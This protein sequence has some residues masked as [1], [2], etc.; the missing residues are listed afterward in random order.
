LKVTFANAPSENPLGAEEWFERLLPVPIVVVSRALAVIDLPHPEVVPAAESFAV[1]MPCPA[2]NGV[3]IAILL[4]VVY[5]GPTMVP[6]VAFRTF[7]TVVES[8]VLPGLFC[9]VLP[10]RERRRTIVLLRERALF[11]GQ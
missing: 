9:F 7:Y 5:V 6:E 11:A 8:A 2:W 1:F 4:A 10:G 3:R